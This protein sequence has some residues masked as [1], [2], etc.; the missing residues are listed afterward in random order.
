MEG[1]KLFLEFVS[2]F[3]PRPKESSGWCAR[4]DATQKFGVRAGLDGVN[5]TGVGALLCI[6]NGCC[7]GVGVLWS[8][9]GIGIVPLVRLQVRDLSVLDASECLRICVLR[10]VLHDLNGNAILA[11]GGYPCIPTF[12]N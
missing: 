1:G 2:D 7:C 9:L 5:F 8:T 10:P 4:G 6:G 11:G 3:A 12:C